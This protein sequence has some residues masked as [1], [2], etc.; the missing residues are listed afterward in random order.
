[1]SGGTG[2]DVYIVDN[3]G[4]V[5]SEGSGSGTDR[6]QSAISYTLGANV[7]NLTLSGSAA[8]NGTGN[9]LNNVLVGNTA[10]NVLKGGAG[11]DSLTGGGGSN[12]F[13]FDSKVGGFDTVTD[14]HCVCDTLLFA[15]TG[16]PVGDADALVENGTVRAAPGGFSTAAEVVIFTT[17]IVGAITTASAAAKIGSATSAYAVGADV[18]FAVDNGTQTGVMLFQSSG[19][20]AL[21]SAAELT[22][23]AL[24][25]GDA[26]T[27]ADY[28][29]T[30]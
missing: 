10:A 7:E 19:T 23:V 21:V 4:D 22:Q 29:F 18:L 17:N 1:L 25:N 27:L 8:T 6:V 12:S 11:A 15:M 5:V 28:V 24:L 3:A 30:P 16:M 26:T 9:T 2:N 14:W 20:D 13:V